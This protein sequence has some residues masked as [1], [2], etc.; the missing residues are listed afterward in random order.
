VDV[1]VVIPTQSQRLVSGRHFRYCVI[2][3]LLGVVGYGLVLSRLAGGEDFVNSYPFI[4]ADGF[5]WLYQGYVLYER[6]RGQC[7]PVL[8]FLRDPGFILVCA[9]D[10]ALQAAGLVVILAHTLSFA[11]TGLALLKAARLYVLP[12]I[13]VASVTAIFLLQ[14][15]NYVR[16]Y[17][18]ADPLAVGL[19]T[20]STYAMLHH[21][22]THS[23]KALTLSAVLAL[24]GG[25]TQ[26]YAAIPFIVGT[27]VSGV[28]NARSRH[29][30]LSLGVVFVGFAACLLVLKVAW[31]AAMPHEELPIPFGSLQL[32]F[33]M[34]PFYARVWS[35]AYVPL[36]PFAG[37][38]L[39]VWW[40]SGRRFHSEVLFLGVTVV[41]FAGL[42]VFYQWAEARFTFIYQPLVLLLLMAL[43]SPA[44]VATARTRRRWNLAAAGA[45]CSAVLVAGSVAVTPLTYYGPPTL[46]WRPRS[47]WILE[48]WFSR[49]VDRF[50]LARSSAANVYS[51]A[52]MPDF[53]PYPG[54][55]VAGYLALRRRQQD[56]VLGVNG[57]ELDA[58]ALEPGCRQ[59][60]R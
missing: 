28:A 2:A 6:L 57:G 16:L 15:L 43:V 48:A 49:P 51:Q 11:A 8:W 3:L 25:M 22:R 9:L 60:L 26:T 4:R 39:L 58:A 35:L 37:T 14:P 12:L 30:L 17:V 20:V 10:A 41:L 40:R 47:S 7:A 56:R 24:L 27:A 42:S 1:S 19:L 21:L 36:L 52:T 23:I 32:S 53:D 44:A 34:V 59:A 13:V 46:T 55:I 33:D 29:S 18:L 45:V 54:K 5:D 50:E 38:A 31:R